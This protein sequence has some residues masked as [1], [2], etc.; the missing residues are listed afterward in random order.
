[1]VICSILNLKEKSI[2]DIHKGDRFRESVGSPKSLLLQVMMP[3]GQAE[4]TRR[5]HKPVTTRRT[6]I[7]IVVLQ[8]FLSG[9]FH[10][11]R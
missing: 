10:N 6:K 3:V 11:I 8:Y 9:A 1:M 7:Q 5:I 4:A 2:P